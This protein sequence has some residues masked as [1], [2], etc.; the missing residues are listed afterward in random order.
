M[1]SENK[2]GA[3]LQTVRRVMGYRELIMGGI[4]CDTKTF[5]GHYHFPMHQSSVVCPCWVGLKIP[6]GSAICIGLGVGFKN[7]TNEVKLRLG[8]VTQLPKSYLLSPT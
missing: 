5:L 2:I 8:A 6:R 4:Y 1:P 3:M 7:P